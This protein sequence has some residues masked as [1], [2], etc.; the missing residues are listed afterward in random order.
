MIK[1]ISNIILVMLLGAAACKDAPPPISQQ[2]NANKIIVEQNNKIETPKSQVQIEK[3][4]IVTPFEVPKGQLK[5]DDL[6][7]FLPDKIAGAKLESPS[8][9]KNRRTE[10]IVWTHASGQY[11]LQNGG[12]VYLSL[13]DYGDGIAD[14][15]KK[16]YEPPFKETGLIV[17]KL[18]TPD[19]NGF[20]LYNEQAKNGNISV[21]VIGRIGVELEV[22]NYPSIDFD[23]LISYINLSGL[24]KAAKSK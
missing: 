3:A 2:Q 8:T 10:T 13:T 20:R 17:E 14:D 12:G 15:I 21:L 23:K 6:A 18:A 7:K 16:R 5:P 24:A 22:L 19:G 1:A 9:G 11:R 4:P